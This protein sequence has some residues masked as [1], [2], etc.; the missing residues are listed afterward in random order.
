MAD[1]GRRLAVAWTSGVRHGRRFRWATGQVIGRRGTYVN[2][3]N[4]GQ[5]GRPQPDNA[6]GNEYCV[7]AVKEPRARHSSWHDLACNNVAHFICER[8]YKYYKK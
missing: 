3:S 5:L 7:A 1:T 2:W 4:S 8:P 6:F